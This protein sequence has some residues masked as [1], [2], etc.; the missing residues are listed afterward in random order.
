MSVDKLLVKEESTFL[1]NL[2]KNKKNFDLYINS[3]IN[4]CYETDIERNITD[5]DNINLIK[6]AIEKNEINNFNNIYI[7]SNYV[8][9]ELASLFANPIVKIWN[10]KYYDE[11]KEYTCY[12][13][14][15]DLKYYIEGIENYI[16][17]NDDNIVPEL[18]NYDL[19][20]IETNITKLTQG[21]KIL[22]LR[23]EI[24]YFKNLPK[25]SYKETI[26]NNNCYAN[27]PLTLDVNTL[28]IL[29]CTG[30]N[31]IQYILGHIYNDGTICANHVSIAT[32]V[33]G[34]NKCLGSAFCSLCQ[35]SLSCNLL[36]YYKGL[37]ENKDPFVISEDHCNYNIEKAKYLAYIYSNIG[38]RKKAID[39]ND[40]DFVSFIDRNL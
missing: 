16:L 21:L 13:Y 38:V 36:C 24:F 5:N 2:Y 37:K 35:A 10:G 27:N 18:L 29:P 15:D 3:G 19:K 26:K 6:N 20:I 4:Y 28:D 12:N 30:I 31:K 1:V 11:Y 23:K 33:I 7:D 39:M 17:L 25:D 9:A 40:T 22:L 32:Q 14:I 34:C 8:S